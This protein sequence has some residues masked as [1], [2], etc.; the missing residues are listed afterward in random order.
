MSLCWPSR[1]PSTEGSSRLR[2]VADVLLRGSVTLVVQQNSARRVSPRQSRS[3]GEGR[4]VFHRRAVACGRSLLVY[5][6][7]CKQPDLTGRRA[8]TLYT[9]TNCSTPGSVLFLRRSSVRRTGIIHDARQ[10][11]TG[12]LRYVS[13]RQHINLLW[14][15]ACPHLSG[16]HRV[17]RKKGAPTRLMSQLFPMA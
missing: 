9:I 5:P 2:S 10:T 6:L 13:G 1:R 11:G 16:Q 15:C 3:G 17:S 14:Q 8:G 4:L 12:T 7:N